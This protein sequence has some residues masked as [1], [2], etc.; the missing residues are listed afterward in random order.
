MYQYVSL[1][2]TGIYADNKEYLFLLSLFMA[3]LACPGLIDNK[4]YI[5]DTCFQSMLVTH[6]IQQGICRCVD[7]INIMQ[8]CATQQFTTLIYISEWH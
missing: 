1:V 3:I 5:V 6:M 2:S 4:C 7:I 8:I